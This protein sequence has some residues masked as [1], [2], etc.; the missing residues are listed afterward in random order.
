MRARQHIEDSSRDSL[1][2]DQIGRS[3]R[4][5]FPRL[6]DSVFYD[7]EWLMT[8]ENGLIQSPNLLFNLY[9]CGIVNL[10]VFG[11]RSPK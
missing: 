7:I 1:Y 9:P 10:G 4:E 8:I 3:E 6:R 11:E 2:A 5:K